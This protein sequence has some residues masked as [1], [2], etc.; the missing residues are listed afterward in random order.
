MAK[1]MF[2]SCRPAACQ[3]CRI[4]QIICRKY[5]SPFPAHLIVLP[6]KKAE[7][8]KKKGKIK[9]MKK[10]KGKIRLA[11]IG[12]GGIARAHARGIGE[13]KDRIECAALCD[14]SENNLKKRCEELGYTPPLFSDWR[15]MLREYGK[16]I[17]AV[18]ICLPHHLHAP[19]ILDAV[20]A[21]KHVLCEKP[22][23][24]SLKDAEKIVTAVKKA[25]ITY[26]S[27]HNQLF[28]P[29]VQEAKKMI[30][31][32]V[33][34]R[35]H[36]LRSQD[37]FR[38]GTAE[39]FAGTW[40]ANLKSQGGGELIDTG[41]HPTY[42]LLY[43]ADAEVVSV[44]CTMG[45][46]HMKIKGEDTASVQVRFHNGAIGEIL[47]SWAFANPSGTHQIHVIGE[48]G[49]IFG[50][51]STLN[52]LPAGYTQPAVMN[53]KQVNTISAQIAHFAECLR[54]GKRPI[55][56]AEEGKQVLE[57]ICQA[58]NNAAGWQKRRAL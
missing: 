3:N 4:Y 38:V 2:F 31:E 56:S 53:L 52:Y 42:R 28:L 14:I 15:K 16:H 20:A 54:T 10:I 23:C 12:A 6:S 9:P 7:N 58:A 30:A 22:M 5:H 21:G 46:F 50:S 1:Y 26:M 17:D 47:T 33:L 51:E 57:I 11:V 24:T 8:I 40:R 41:Y 19:A 48:N 35:I 13:H 32:G 37:C 44:R 29:I 49:Q 18:D 43:L 45:R 55:H 27:A 39:S 25:G 36:W 34:G